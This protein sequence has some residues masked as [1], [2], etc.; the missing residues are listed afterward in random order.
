M[1][2]LDRRGLPGGDGLKGDAVVVSLG[3]DV[4]ERRVLVIVIP[5]RIP[6]IDTLRRRWP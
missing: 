6:D 3:R 1:I 2:D 4:V 5:D